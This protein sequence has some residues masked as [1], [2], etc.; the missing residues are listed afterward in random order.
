M[1]TKAKHD[2]PPKKVMGLA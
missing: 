1:N 2:M